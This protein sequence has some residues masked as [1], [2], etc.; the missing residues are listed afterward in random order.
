VSKAKLHVLNHD[1]SHRQEV[2]DQLVAAAKTAHDRAVHG[3]FILMIDEH[4]RT[5]VKS[6][7]TLKK[8]NAVVAEL[9]KF[10][11]ITSLDD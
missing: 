8:K 11:V 6:A 7:G 3:A 5:I 1:R 10:T 4:G 2:A 9:M